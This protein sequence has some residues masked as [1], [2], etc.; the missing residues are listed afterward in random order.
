ML[1][2]RKFALLIVLSTIVVVGAL[3]SAFVVVNLW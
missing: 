1:S 2:P 3:F